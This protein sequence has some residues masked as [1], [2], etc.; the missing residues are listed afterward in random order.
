MRLVGYASTREDTLIRDV[1]NNYTATHLQLLT[2]VLHLRNVL[3]QSVDED[4][5]DH[6]WNGDEV[7]FN[8]L[9]SG[10]Y[11]FAVAFLAVLALGGVI[12]PLCMYFC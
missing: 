4:A 7:A 8:I 1:T 2:D 5:R 12:V 9:A 11:E 3:Y 6:L 10:G